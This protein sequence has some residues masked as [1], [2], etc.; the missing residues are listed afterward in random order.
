MKGN[1]CNSIRPPNISTSNTYNFHIRSP[2]EVHEYLMEIL[3]HPLSNRSSPHLQIP[4]MRAV[5]A[6]RRCRVTYLGQFGPCNH[7]EF[8]PYAGRLPRQPYYTHEQFHLPYQQLRVA[9]PSVFKLVD[10]YS[11]LGFCLLSISFGK[12]LFFT[13]VD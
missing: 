9:S 11:P 10:P 5:I 7:T 2:F 12:L 13:C 8:V 1:I 6:K 3:S 4:S